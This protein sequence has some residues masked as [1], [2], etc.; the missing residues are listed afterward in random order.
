MVGFIPPS[1]P[2]AERQFIEI[3]KYKSRHNNRLLYYDETK[4]RCRS[5]SWQ[6][7]MLD[8]EDKEEIEQIL[9]R[10]GQTFQIPLVNSM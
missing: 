9:K 6:W 1:V 8:T 3:K 2:F 5:K 7:K 10:L 4:S